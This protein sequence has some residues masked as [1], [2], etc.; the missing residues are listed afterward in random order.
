MTTRPYR[1]IFATVLAVIAAYAQGGIMDVRP[2]SMS[3]AKA[4]IVISGMVER[5]S[6]DGEKSLPPDMRIKL[7][8]HGALSDGGGVELSGQ[9]RFTM[10][11]DPMAIVADNICVAEAKSFGYDSTVAKFPVRSSSG[12]VNIGVITVTR[13]S[14]GDAQD[15]GGE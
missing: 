3:D 1:L 2:I 7:D 9:F 4:T 6:A 13:N 12:L 15:H 5:S 11:P 8:C 10:T 14:T